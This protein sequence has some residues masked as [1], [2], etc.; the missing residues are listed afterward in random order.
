MN[1]D[2]M[3][4]LFGQKDNYYNVVYSDHALKVDTGRLYAVSTKEDVKKSADVF[5][6]IMRSMIVMM[7]TAAALIFLIVLY[8]I[9]SNDR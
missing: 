7:I 8:Q 6:D 1:L 3:R 2:S 9:E 4:E 5:V